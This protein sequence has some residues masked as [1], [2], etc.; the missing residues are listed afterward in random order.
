MMT[1]RR[2]PET[3]HIPAGRRSFHEALKRE[4]GRVG[5]SVAELSR[6]CQ[7]RPAQVS[8]WEEDVAVPTKLEFKRL[9]GSIRQMR[10]FPP[11]FDE[12]DDS[13]PAS[14]VE[15][16]PLPPNA[17]AQLIA[18]SSF[19]EA[20]RREREL[21]GLSQSDLASILESH[22]SDVSR[23]E[24]GGGLSE[25]YFD[26]LLEL[27]PRLADARRPLLVKAPSRLKVPLGELT[28]VKSAPGEKHYEPALVRLDAEGR[29]PREPK[30]SAPSFAELP[31]LDDLT[32]ANLA[33]E[34]EP[35]PREK[36]TKAPRRSALER[37]NEMLEA[38]EGGSWSF[39]F[40]ATKEGRWMLDASNRQD[41]EAHVSHKHVADTPDE[42]VEALVR[43]TT[44][45]IEKQAEDLR[46]QAARLEKMKRST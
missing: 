32:K 16:L 24:R 10:F 40:R 1:E 9:V 33:D 25:H 41:V 46:A 23:W 42:A 35:A 44:V 18:L 22:Q 15:P 19:G 30:P 8:D 34:A 5:L 45:R 39:T 12:K 17:S 2:E 14:A 27:F 37:C 13:P 31:R 29:D 26:K 6:R 38:F 21:E 7:V 11:I 28:L 36:R 3:I 43:A 20:L 4:R